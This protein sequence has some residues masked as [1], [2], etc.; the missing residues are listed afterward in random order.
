MFYWSHASAEKFGGRQ[1][2]AD[3]LENV[4]EWTGG[5]EKVFE[6]SKIVVVKKSV[7]FLHLI[8]SGTHQSTAVSL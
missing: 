8:D 6:M 7:F 4:I 3:L 5:M 1:S 2:L